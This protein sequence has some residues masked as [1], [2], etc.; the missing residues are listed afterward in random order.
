MVLTTSNGEHGLFMFFCSFSLIFQSTCLK[1]SD[2]LASS[3]VLPVQHCGAVEVTLQQGAFQFRLLYRS[4]KLQARMWEQGQDFGE[5]LVSPEG[6]A[7]AGA[8]CP[9]PAQD[10]HRPGPVASAE[11]SW[12]PPG[13]VQLSQPPAHSG[14]SSPASLRGSCA[15]SLRCSH[16]CSCSH[17]VSLSSAVPPVMSCPP[18]AMGASVPLYRTA[19]FTHSLLGMLRSFTAGTPRLQGAAGSS[20]SALQSLTEP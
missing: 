15:Q 18:N 17:P 6:L 5:V 11:L 10:S 8:Q 20:K 3:L 13:V 9:E 19:A 7:G 2:F 12:T 1:S 16:H 4:R 14:F